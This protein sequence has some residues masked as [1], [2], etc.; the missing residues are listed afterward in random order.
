MPELLARRVIED[1]P[2]A[3]GENLSA[4]RGGEPLHG[5]P[6]RVRG[7]H[8]GRRIGGDRGRITPARAGKTYRVRLFY[9]GIRDHPRACG[10]NRSACW[11][12]GRRR[13]SPPRVRGKPCPNCLL[14]ALSRITPARAGKT[15]IRLRR[16]S[17]SWDH[18]R[19]CGENSARLPMKRS[20]RGSPPRVRGKR[21][22]RQWRRSSRRI[23]PARAGKTTAAP[24]QTR[25]ASDHPRAC[26][27]NGSGNGIQ[28]VTC[29]SPPR[30]RGK[31]DE[32]PDGLLL[33]RITPARA[34]KT[35]TGP[36]NTRRNRDHPRACGE[37]D[38]FAAATS[39]D[40]GS[41]PR[42]RGKP[43]SHT[44]MFFCLRITPARAGKTLRTMSFPAAAKD[45]PRAC[46]EN[47]TSARWPMRTAGSPPRVRGKPSLNFAFCPRFR[48]TPARAG[49]TCAQDSP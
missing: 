46:G 8:A 7:K 34:G 2:R 24:F 38:S 3:C 19:A 10:E 32:H 49:K 4:L 1:H 17:T 43:L 21:S 25:A 12:F 29:G 37:N 18:P 42:V 36:A 9:V 44:L 5:S 45:H 22:F 11:R 30:V 48:I 47:V 23:T 20:G 31:L 35:C 28:W 41:P 40:S 6:P 33:S 16:I 26:G 39:S 14:A 27:E 13:G 15:L